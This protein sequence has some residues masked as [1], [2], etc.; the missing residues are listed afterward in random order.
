[1][2]YKNTKIVMLTMGLNWYPWT[3]QQ[4]VGIPDFQKLH[5]CYPS[6]LKHLFNVNFRVS[7]YQKGFYKTSCANDRQQDK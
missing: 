5:K 2:L 1:M 3:L 6:E 7:V 4:I